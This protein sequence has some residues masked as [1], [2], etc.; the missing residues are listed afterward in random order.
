MS[1]ELLLLRHAKSDWDAL[2]E[3]DADRVLSKRG[4]RDAPLVGEWL[5]NEGL[6]PEVVVC[7]P[8]VRTR[9][10]L[11][12]VLERLD[13]ADFP[14]AFDRR[15]YEASLSSL[16]QVLA[17][18]PNTVQRTLLVGHNPGVDDLVMYLASNPPPLTRSGK[19]MTTAALARIEL[20]DDWSRLSQGCGSVVCLM[21]PKELISARGH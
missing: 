4:R 1:R 19:L 5:A 10:T 14:V 13:M 3:R 16:L 21:R 15:I 11:T 12:A 20:P 6:I 7:S 17:D 2:T 8:A 9:Q 18:Y